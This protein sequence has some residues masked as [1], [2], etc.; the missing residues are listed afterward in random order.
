[1]SD[2][3]LSKE[4]V[5]RLLT[6]H[7]AEARQ[8]TAVKL[9]SQ[10]NAASLTD[11]ERALAEDIFRVMVRDAEVKVRQA[12]SEQL[13]TSH[14]V[15]HDVALTLANDVDNVALPMLQFSAVLTDKDL[16]EIIQTQDSS[17]QIAV[18]QRSSVNPKVAAALVKSGSVEVSLTLAKNRGAN[19]PPTA[20]H[21]II[22]KYGDDERF[23]EPLVARPHLPATVAEKLVY[24]VSEALRDRIVETQELPP[25]LA[26]DLVMQSL[27]RATLAVSA[28]NTSNE[29]EVERL[30]QQME[31]HH[32]LTP[33]IITRA[34]MMGDLKFFEYALAVKA[35]IPVINARTLIY[36]PGHFGLS[37][38]LRRVGV[39]QKWYPAVQAALDVARETEYDG[40]L[41]D[42][43]RFKRKMLERILTQTD[44]RGLEFDNDELEYL[45]EKM[46]HTPDAATA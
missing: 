4:D 3:T 29:E 6:D 8:E 20:L 26:A 10:Y 1:M 36:D 9:A 13:R 42:R 38:I 39:S 27:E 19:L 45:L 31:N 35:R 12:L 15:P 24:K 17:K 44:L 11:A 21:Q 40:G 46:G 32:R 23:H 37:G 2:S 7:S 5:A 22:D 25:N 33:S 30:V 43:E 16:L 28:T 34:V 18:A 41:D 14:A